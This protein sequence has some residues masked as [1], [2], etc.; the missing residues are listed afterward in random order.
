MLC[1]TPHPAVAFRIPL[2]QTFLVDDFRTTTAFLEQ[3]NMF[4]STTSCPYLDRLLEKKQRFVLIVVSVLWSHLC[5]TPLSIVAGFPLDR[6]LLVNKMSSSSSNNIVNNNKIYKN[7]NWKQLPKPDSSSSTLIYREDLKSR[8]TWNHDVYMDSWE[9]YQRFLESSDNY[10]DHPIRTALTSLDHAFRLYGPQSVV[11][12][13][14]GGKDAVVILHLLRAAMAA[15]YHQR[16]Q[17]QQEQEQP[18]SENTKNVPILRPR[19][20]YFDH[21]DEFPEIL[22]FVNA[23]VQEFDLDMVAFAQDTKFQDGLKVL[24]DNNVVAGSDDAVVLPMAFVLGTRLTD[25]NAVG[26]QPF[27]PSSHYMPPFMRVNPIL[28]WT[29]G[30]VW[31]FLRLFQLSYCSLYDKGY[32][33]LGTVKDTLPCPALAVAGY[34]QSDGSIPKY[35]PAYMLRDWDQERA[36]R[37]SKK[38]KSITSS[39]HKP[40]KII[41]NVNT[42]T[43]DESETTT[44]R[45]AIPSVSS[46]GHLSTLSEGRRIVEAAPPPAPAQDAETSANGVNAIPESVSFS[47]DAI[48]Q[49]TA[50]LLIIGDE[51]LKGLT[52][53]VNTQVAAVALRSQNVVLKC[54]AVISD[55]LD[56]I[57]KEIRR[58]QTCV[59]VIITSGGVGPTHDE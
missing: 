2:L 30:H 48:T 13:F 7:D 31:H 41:K 11:C 52:Q 29:Y 53:D 50:G 46:I 17:T 15:Y 44:E 19:V 40:K 9:L 21:K 38:K 12:S 24:V 45:S 1:A 54:V 42:T 33:S 5:F 25:P 10:L 35:W 55:D 3:L 8:G 28:S 14:N 34:Q 23:T 18:S 49:K 4:T 6:L 32:T 37:I 56:E 27:A 58:L 43:T 20:V 47:S 57:A 39:S 36:G 16:Q 26:Q 22:E 59:D 51:I